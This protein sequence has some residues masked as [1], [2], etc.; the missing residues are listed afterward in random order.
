MTIKKEETNPWTSAVVDEYGSQKLWRT[1]TFPSN[2]MRGETSRRALIDD[3]RELHGTRPRSSE[4]TSKKIQPRAYGFILHLETSTREKTAQLQEPDPSLDCCRTWMQVVAP[5]EKHHWLIE[6]LKI[7]ACLGISTDEQLR[8]VG[9]LFL[10][11]NC[12]QK[13]LSVVYDGESLHSFGRM[14]WAQRR[15]S[16]HFRLVAGWV[17]ERRR[18]GGAFAGTVNI[19]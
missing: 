8:K 17:S 6:G 16:Q 7:P 1:F 5:G 11:S 2:L 3:W 15:Y 18:T 13:C 14:N 4:E 9:M 12:F 19:Q 10:G